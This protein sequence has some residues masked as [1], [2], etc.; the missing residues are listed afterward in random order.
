MNQRQPSKFLLVVAFLQAILQSSVFALALPPALVH[1]VIGGIAG[2]TGA[3]AAY[4]IDYVKSQ[5]Q[6]KEGREKYTGGIDAA[7]KIST[8]SKLGPLALYRGSLVNIVGILPEKA[9]KLGV[10]DFLR[11]AFMG[12][13]GSLT[14]LAEVVAG[15]LA[16]LAQV[17]ATNPLEVV[18]VR[19][20]TSDMSLGEILNG[21]GGFMGLYS[22]AG[23]CMLRDVIFSATLFPLYA[24]AKE[25]VP[26]ILSAISGG[27]NVSSILSGIIAGSLAAAPAAFIATPADLIKT[28]MQQARPETGIDAGDQHE[29]S[30]IVFEYKECPPMGRN[31]FSVGRDI[32]S[33]EGA[34]VLFSGAFERVVRSIPQFGV[35]LALFDVLTSLAEDMGLLA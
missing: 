32:V 11:G 6:T 23:A 8:R 22:G 13:F 30:N 31:P 34:S 21:V 25:F 5:L 3:L 12:Y 20:Q 2:G 27:A 10:N 26:E 9:I 29:K 1:G 4:P 35:T 7:V 24:H 18:K 17:V 19:M 33:N 28:R 16:G 14:I 15:G